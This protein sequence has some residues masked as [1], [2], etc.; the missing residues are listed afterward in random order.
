[1]TVGRISRRTRNESTC[2]APPAIR[3]FSRKTIRGSSESGGFAD[4]VSPSTIVCA[5]CSCSKK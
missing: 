1:M 4:A 5:S 2:S 3:L